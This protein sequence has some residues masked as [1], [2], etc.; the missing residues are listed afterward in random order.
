MA[1]GI[2]V[3]ET[4]C[5][6]HPEA[7]G[8]VERKRVYEG[9][10]QAIGAAEFSEARAIVAEQAILRAHPEKSSAIL[11]HAEHIEISQPF[12]VIL[13]AIS[14]SGRWQTQAEQYCQ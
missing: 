13:E 12:D 9:A 1:L 8:P 11:Q 7:A 10:G 3:K 4:F 2:E 5:G 14:L 6:A